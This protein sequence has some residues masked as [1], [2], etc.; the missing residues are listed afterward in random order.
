G[1][2][3]V[4]TRPTTHSIWQIDG[5]PVGPWDMSGRGTFEH[6]INNTGL[7]LPSQTGDGGLKNFRYLLDEKGGL[8]TLLPLERDEHPDWIRMWCQHGICID[9]RV[10]LSFIKVQMLKENTGPLPIAFEIVGSGLA[11]GNRGEWKFKRITRDGNDILWRADEPHFATAFLQHPSDGHVYLFGTVQKNGKQECYVAC[12]CGGIGNVEAYTYLA[13]HEPRWSTNVADAISVFDGM[14]SEL[15][16]SFNKHLGKF[17][18]VHSLDLSGKIV[19]R[20]APEPWGPW[21][22]PVTLWQ[23]EAKHEFPRPYPITL[24][25]AG[26]EH[27]ELAGDGGRTIYLTYIE[28]EEYF[29]HLV[30]VTLA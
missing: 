25:Y 16:V 18:A 26:K 21:S 5:Q 29:P 7:I 14:P 12:A 27:P 11:V 17:L 22:D 28:F 15:S 24:I 3:L 10:Y 20:T 9:R 4:G 30:E 13:S 23:C 2:T 1:D 8:K 6:M 19:A